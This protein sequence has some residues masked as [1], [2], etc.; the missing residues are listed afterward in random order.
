VWLIQR[1]APSTAAVVG[2]HEEE[3]SS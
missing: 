2:M 3:Q 1:P